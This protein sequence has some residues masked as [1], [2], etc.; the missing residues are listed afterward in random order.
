MHKAPIFNKKFIFASI[1][2]SNCVFS[3]DAHTTG[4][5]PTPS[6]QRHA[7]PRKSASSFRFATILPAARLG[8]TNITTAQRVPCVSCAHREDF[9]QK[10]TPNTEFSSLGC[11]DG[12]T[13]ALPAEYRQVF[14]VFRQASKKRA[15]YVTLPRKRT[16]LRRFYQNARMVSLGNI[17]RAYFVCCCVF[18]HFALRAIRNR[19]AVSP[20]HRR[21][22][23]CNKSRASKRGNLQKTR[24]RCWKSSVSMRVSA[25]GR[26]NLF[27]AKEK[28]GKT[29]NA[30]WRVL[31]SPIAG[32]KNTFPPRIAC[33]SHYT[34]P[35]FSGSC[36]RNGSACTDMPRKCPCLPIPAWADL[37]RR[38]RWIIRH[39]SI[40]LFCRMSHD[41]LHMLW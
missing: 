30:L 20:K 12:R 4:T 10:D 19:N 8:A 22:S 41:I 9:R 5:L 28:S 31:K 25:H 24:K 35:S 21:C 16:S 34:S 38:N 14:A 18:Q 29:K 37:P 40:F 33:G 23:Q 26:H 13:N 39:F 11:I 17:P 6:V 27:P 36:L 7:F 1:F 3:A 32:I 15:L 2:G